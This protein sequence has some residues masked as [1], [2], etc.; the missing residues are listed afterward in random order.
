M[1]SRLSLARAREAPPS[2]MSRQRRRAAATTRCSRA[3]P[4]AA[5]PRATGL[6][7]APLVVLAPGVLQGLLAPRVPA[8]ARGVREP[9]ECRRTKWMGAL[10]MPEA[11]TGVQEMPMHPEQ[12]TRTNRSL[13]G[14]LCA[15]SCWAVWLCLG[16][17]SCLNPLPDDQ[18]SSRGPATPDA[19]HVD[20]INPNAGSPAP[21]ESPATPAANPQAPAP[22]GGLAGEDSA[23][24]PTGSAA[25]PDAGAPSA[26]AGPDA[27]PA[28]V[29]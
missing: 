24:S 19:I 23:A 22:A 5:T 25:G 15:I 10:E 13:I 14:P 3:A 17:T 4:R 29:Q 21:P 28:V 9:E 1:I 7:P 8:E 20:E 16:P 12:R 26:D 27:Q 6:R 11:T 18:P 2:S